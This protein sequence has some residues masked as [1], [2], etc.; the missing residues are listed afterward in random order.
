MK[1]LTG[2]GLALAMLLA[3]P[4]LSAQTIGGAETKPPDQAAAK[5]PAQATG[6]AET[7]PSDQARSIPF[8]RLVTRFDAPTQWGSL[9]GGIFCLPT[10]NLTF[11][12]GELNVKTTGFIDAYNAEVKKAGYKVPGESDNL[13]ENQSN[14]SEYAVAGTIKSADAHFCRPY[15]GYGNVSTTKGHA[16]LSIEWQIYSYIEK[17]VIA[18]IN[19]TGSFEQKSTQPGGIESILN[20]AFAQNVDQLV[21]SPEFRKAANGPITETTASVKPEAQPTLAYLPPIASPSTIADAVSGVVVVF[22]GETQG[23]AFLISRDGYFLTNAHVVGDARFVKIHWS[24]GVE[25]L[26]EVVRVSKGRDVAL[27]KSDPRG[28]R[29]LLMAVGAGRPGDPVFAIGAPLGVK[30]ESTVTKGIYSAFRQYGGYDFIQS[31]VTVNPGDS[32]GPLLNEH[33]AVIGLTVSSL[34]IAALIPTGLNMFIP[35]Q[36]ALRFLALAPAGSPAALAAAKAPSGAAPPAP[37]VSAPT[38]QDGAPLTP[39]DPPEPITPS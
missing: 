9:S 4:K 8:T 29:P 38:R 26:G 12:A 3:A 30:F 13:F 25:G 27:V 11:K 33:A 14:T 7:K 22:A 18:K 23:S 21:A 24:D 36:D 2:A 5:A 1:P 34:R 17:R 20:Q 37:P 19:T 16:T 10:G 6:E 35:I 15:I 28:R 39:A 31:D 32:G